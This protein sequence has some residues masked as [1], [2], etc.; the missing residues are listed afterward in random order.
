M[1][2]RINVSV[3]IVL[4][5]EKG[6][7]MVVQHNLA[8]MNSNRQ[9]GITTGL[10]AR[11]SE[12]L[13]SGYRINRAADD[14]A[15]LAISE[16]MRRQIRGLSKG[17]ENVQ[18]GI[19]LLQVADGALVEVHDMLQRLN[20]LAVKAS[21]ETLQSTDRDYIQ[22]EVD[23]IKDEIDHIGATASFNERL[24]FD[25]LFPNGNMYKKLSDVIKSSAAETGSLKEAYFKGGRYYPS[26]TLDFSRVDASVISVLDGKGFAFTCAQN[27]SEV[28]KFT[29][30]TST[31]DCKIEGSTT[32]GSGTHN[33]IIG[34][35][36]CSS[37]VD[38][39]NKMF[40]FAYR[41][42]LTGAEQTI[43]TPQS[44]AVSHSNT[45]DRTGDAKF[46]L[47]GNVGSYTTAGQ[48]KNHTF[49]PG[50]GQVD[51]SSFDVVLD[52]DSRNLWIHSG[53][54]SDEGM[55]I[56]IN[57]VNTDTIGIKNLDVTSSVT[58]RLGIDK[59]KEAIGTVSE[60][61][62]TLG[63]QQ[64][65]LEHTLR[66]NLN[67]EEN[68]QASESKIRDTDMAEEMVRY[69]NNNIL[70]QAGQAMLAQANQT[71]QGVLSLLQ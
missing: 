70:A 71:N 4:L 24:L 32:R 1:Q 66:N 54:N 45:I 2:G 56:T 49:S 20:E 27:C 13:S 30:D 68:T 23:Q 47:W 17:T 51:C 53:L 55:Y 63:A 50:M 21:N 43:N 25:D 15:G 6:C 52:G 37:G 36:D 8:A 14:A 10:Q 60:E 69:S 22:R 12:K 67:R 58:A 31:S 38:I 18:E 59:V 62:A 3:D 35:K 44:I 29:F 61:R 16:K 19:S 7:S 48:V 42:P 41:N 9:L 39:V 26:A 34:I 11:S 33:Y 46:V 28:F 64:N 40:D 65:R 57:R 5:K